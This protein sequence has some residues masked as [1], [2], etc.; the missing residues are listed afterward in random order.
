MLVAEDSLQAIA[1]AIRAKNGSQNTYTPGEMAA[2]IRAISGGN[3]T[4]G[5]KTIFHN[6]THQASGESLDGYSSVAVDVHP[7]LL[8]PYEEDLTTG[9]V[10]TSVV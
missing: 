8:E 6:G 7:G 4:L 10:D 5:T 9:Y 3:A 2:A 1:D